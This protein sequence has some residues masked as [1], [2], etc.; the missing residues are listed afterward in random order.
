MEHPAPLKISLGR[1][2]LPFVFFGYAIILTGLAA[3]LDYWYIS[4]PIILLGLFFVTARDYLVIDFARKRLI[5]TSTYLFMKNSKIVDVSNAEFISLV[6]V[7]VSQQLYH[8]SIGT[9]IN[10][11]MLSAYV[12]F[13]GNKKIK[14][15]RK[16]FEESKALTSTIANGLQLRLLDLSTGKKVWMEPAT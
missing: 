3:L 2:P 11:V 10:D 7:N 9:T 15:F 13:P 16:K 8:Q 1:L 5:K 4:V 6:R 12:I 14:L